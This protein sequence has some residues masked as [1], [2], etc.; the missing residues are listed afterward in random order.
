MGSDIVAQLAGVRERNLLQPDLDQPSSA[1]QIW[2]AWVPAQTLVE[3]PWEAEELIDAASAE[4]GHL[5][6]PGWL[7]A[8]AW[9]RAEAAAWGLAQ[10]RP[11]AVLPSAWRPARQRPR[12]IRTLARLKRALAKGFH[13]APRRR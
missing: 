13:R 12:A 6:G 4:L 1:A 9:E 2:Q 8:Y 11:Q 7:R 5:H 3:L 10:P